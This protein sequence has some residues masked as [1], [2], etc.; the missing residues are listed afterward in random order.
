MNDVIREWLHKGEA[1]LL[2]ARRESAAVDAPNF[3]AACFHAQQAAE[4]LMKALLIAANEPPPRVHDL[5]VLGDL[6]T[7][8]FPNWSF[9]IEE[10]RFLSRAAVMF[11][12]PGESAERQDA[13]EAVKIADELCTGLRKLLTDAC[14]A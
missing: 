12:Y 6:I 11:R 3:D 14:K 5:V 7:A 1:D 8:R 2:T 10:L 13:D 4:K 9:P